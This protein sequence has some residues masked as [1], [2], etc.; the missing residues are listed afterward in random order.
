M[1]AAGC[2]P[3]SESSKYNIR[4]KLNPGKSIKDAAKDQKQ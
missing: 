1:H 4:Q 3:G 2:E